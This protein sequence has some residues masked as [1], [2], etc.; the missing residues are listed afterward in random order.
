MDLTHIFSVACVVGS[1]HRTTEGR[2][3]SV[4]V[5]HLS[6]RYILSVS[7]S[8]AAAEFGI[9]WWLTSSQLTLIEIKLQFVV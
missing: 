4:G 3:H 1:W 2:L 7:F 9:K 8:V 6:A 5:E